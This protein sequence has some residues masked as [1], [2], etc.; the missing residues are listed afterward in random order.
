MKTLEGRIT[1]HYQRK[2]IVRGSLFK[3]FAAASLLGIPILFL[4]EFSVARLPK[5]ES[6][7]LASFIPGAIAHVFNLVQ[8]LFVVFITLEAI[9]KREKDATEVL[10]ARSLSNSRYRLG[11][12]AGILFS[13]LIV[14]VFVLGI[15][16]LMH[17]LISESPFE[18]L[19]Y[20][21]CFVTQNIPLLVFV[22]GLTAFIVGT[23]RNYQLAAVLALGILCLCFVFLPERGF[24]AFDPFGIHVP[25]LFSDIVGHVNMGWWVMQRLSFLLAGSALVLVSIRW[26]GRIPNSARQIKMYTY[27][28]VT[29]LLA[30][31][32]VGSVPVSSFVQDRLARKNFREIYGK[33]KGNVHVLE[34]RLTISQEDG[35]I[36][37]SDEMSLSLPVNSDTL[38]LYLNPALEVKQIRGEGKPLAF[39]RE[40]Q[41]VIVESPR[42]R[43]QRL[44]IDYEG[45]IDERIAY[46]DISD[47]LYDNTIAPGVTWRSGRRHAF[48][49]DDFTLLT[50]EVLWYPVGSPPVNVQDVWLSRQEFSSFVLKVLHPEHLTAVAQG[51]V[52][53]GEGYTVFVNE[54]PLLGLALCVGAFEKRTLD[55]ESYR[56]TVHY[57]KGHDFLF[58]SFPHLNESFVK[59]ALENLQISQKVPAYPFRFLE[60][61]EVPVSFTSYHREWRSNSEHV[62]PGMILFPESGCT[63]RLLTKQAARD[64]ILGAKD[65]IMTEFSLLQFFINGYLVRPEWSGGERY[66]TRLFHPRGSAPGFH[67]CAATSLFRELYSRVSSGDIPLLDK[68]CHTLIDEMTILPKLPLVME[69]EEI[70]ARKLVAKRELS[71][72]MEDPLVSRAVKGEVIDMKTRDLYRRLE[73]AGIRE[74]FILTLKEKLAKPGDVPLAELARDFEPL[75]AL[76]DRWYHRRDTPLLLIRGVESGVVEIDGER[77]HRIIF[78]VYNPTADEGVAELFVE[79]LPESKLTSF[80]YPVA[81]FSGQRISTKGHFSI[82]FLIGTGI[83]KNIPEFQVFSFDREHVITDTATGVF[84]LPGYLPP[85]EGEIIVDNESR[86]FELI[87]PPRKLA[88]RLVQYIFPTNE[89]PIMHSLHVA[90]RWKKFVSPALYG[91]TL[92]SAYYKTEGK[93]NFKARWSVRIP[94]T[95]DYEVFASYAPLCFS[96]AISVST[97]SFSGSFSLHYTVSHSNGEERVSVTPPKLGKDYTWISLGTFHLEKGIASVTLDDNG[98][99]SAEERIALDTRRKESPNVHFS[100]MRQAIVADAVKWVK[101]SDK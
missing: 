67:A 58:Q 73:I 32:I 44:E 15:T 1:A 65:P 41:V 60:L 81:P 66:L 88:D 33:Y 45:S 30:S 94:E 48:V 70:I 49:G 77:E 24:G 56:V 18:V 95:G 80:S 84:A 79:I 87:E 43:L 74:E 93:G 19:P 69:Q 97:H 52:T 71:S 76:L 5:W 3:L 6:I 2:L 47:E 42:N 96:G 23:C 51:E 16:M 50:P 4:C 21:F 13:C 38:V 10:L 68:I 28:G 63:F 11:K 83:S 14:N 54:D 90:S 20:L 75:A 46:L 92:R 91:D 37:A 29:L 78:D 89:K 27:A 64:I 40:G 72:I 61:V 59:G 86:N 85:D 22:V 9:G 53:R 8:A 99:M 7:A 26:V 25:N 35:R 62:Q 12:I 82:T 98:G 34:H 101:Q 36:I 39:R 100:E 55:M 31:I 17:A 57:L